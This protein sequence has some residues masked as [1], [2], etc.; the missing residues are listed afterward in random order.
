MH[1]GPVKYHVMKRFSLTI[2]LLASLACSEVGLKVTEYKTVSGEEAAPWNSGCLVKAEDR[3]QSVI[4]LYGLP[5]EHIQIG[6]KAIFNK[7]GDSVFW[8]N[9][10]PYNVRS[11]RFR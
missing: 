2:L 1:S 5:C 3:T 9:D 8:V 6:D 7:Q 11:A 10:I 4:G